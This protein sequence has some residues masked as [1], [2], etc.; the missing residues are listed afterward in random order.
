VC[1]WRGY[2][3]VNIRLSKCGGL[4]RCWQIID[5]LRARGVFFQIGC[6]L[7]ESGILSAAGRTLSLLC[8]DALYH[9]G[10]YDA[11]LL[12]QNPA[13]NVSFGMAG[14]AGPLEGPGWGVAVD[15]DRL[16]AMSAPALCHTLDRP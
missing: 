13:Q 11:F 10:S 8:S 15:P 12:Q 14:L 3:M 16:A 5:D 4:R 9:D 2:D 6:Q 1:G 7:G